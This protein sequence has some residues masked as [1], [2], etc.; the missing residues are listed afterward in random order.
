VSRWDPAGTKRNYKSGAPSVG[1]LVAWDGCAYLVTHVAPSE[2]LDSEPREQ[3]Y[4]DPYLMTIQRIHGPANEHENDMQERALRVPANA[5]H[6]WQSYE[7]GRV[8][9]CSCCG[10]PWPCTVSEAKAMSERQAE[11]LNAKMDRATPGCCYSCGEVISHRQGSITYPEPNVELLGFP[12]PRFHT[13]KSCAEGLYYYEQKRA[14][15]LP[16]AAPVNHRSPSGALW[17]EGKH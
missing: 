11:V 17:Q 13:R 5:Y 16:D 15:A 12:A 6:A 7:E 3:V 9:L 2:L 10:H 14:K 4:R 8:P 1:D